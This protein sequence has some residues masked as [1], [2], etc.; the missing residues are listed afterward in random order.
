MPTRIRCHSPGRLQPTHLAFT[1][2]GGGG[3]GGGWG[4]GGWGGVGVRSLPFVLHYARAQSKRHLPSFE[5]DEPPL[6]PLFLRLREPSE[7]SSPD[8]VIDADGSGTMDVTELVQAR[9]PANEFSARL[10]FSAHPKTCQV[11][12]TALMPLHGHVEP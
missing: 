11:A 6:H 10:T 7:V 9:D 8:K 5:P 3:V 12:A 2:K 4:G 1:N